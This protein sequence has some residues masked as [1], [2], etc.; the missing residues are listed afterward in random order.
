MEL[1]VAVILLITGGTDASNITLTY[2]TSAQMTI[3]E[4]L[5][6]AATINNDMDSPYVMYCGP[7]LGGEKA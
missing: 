1:I 5:E 2:Q 7:I 4:C 6:Q 3:D